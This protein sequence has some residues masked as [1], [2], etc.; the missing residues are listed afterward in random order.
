MAR[1]ELDLSDIGPSFIGRVVLIGSA[2]A[3]VLIAAW[4]FTPILLA[5]YNSA[6]ATVATAPKTATVQPQT[7]VAAASAA[8][9][10]APAPGNDAASTPATTAVASTNDTNAPPP[11]AAAA[12][13]APAPSDNGLSP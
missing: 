9:Q 1:D 3:V 2:V 11:A 10:A 6:R 13:A 8:A 12:P 7:P 4:L 5:K